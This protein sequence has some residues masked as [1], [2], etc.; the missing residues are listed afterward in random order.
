MPV[1][2]SPLD[3]P[4]RLLRR[5]LLLLLS[6]LS[7]TLLAAPRPANRISLE[8]LG[9][10]PL[11]PR[12]LLDGSSMLALH[13]VDDTHLLVT[14]DARHL[15][16]RIPNDPPTDQDHT[17]AFL[18]LELPT[19]RLLAR[20][21]LLVH[22][23]GQYLWNLGNGEFLLRQRD[24]FTTFVPLRN[25]ASGKAFVQ[26]PFLHTDRH[27]VAVLLSP[28]ADFLTIESTDP[29][30]LVD[31]DPTFASS[32]GGMSR[33]NDAPN[34][35]APTHVQLNFYRL[36]PPEPASGQIIPRNAGIALSRRP[37]ELPLSSE[38]L[39]NVLDQGRQR[40]AFDFKSHAGKRIE[41]AL[42]DSTCRPIPYFISPSEFLVFG[43][44]GGVT[45]Q[46][47]AAFNLRGD[48]T[49][50]QV[51][52]GSYVSPSFV[53]AP[54]A[55][56]FAL[57]RLI[58]NAAVAGIDTL[59]PSMV[60]GESVDVIQNDSGK[61]L[62]HIDCTPATRAGQ[63]FALSPDG[64][65]LAVIRD[66]GIEIYVLPALAPQDKTAIQLAVKSAPPP[67]EAAVDL[68]EI[69][70][71]TQGLPGRQNSQDTNDTIPFNPSPATSQSVT[72]QPTTAVQPPP[73]PS[74][75]ASPTASPTQ[76]SNPTAAPT[77]ADPPVRRKP[78]TLYN[79]PA[80]DPA[81][82]PQ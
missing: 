9:F 21:E 24:S 70:T 46:T 47:I 40:W 65:N 64:M 41:L 54:S 34:Q 68:S 81:Q 62:F 36:S 43:C 78:P 56:R 33:S 52:P 53:F 50:Q 61:T 30:P 58:I 69:S 27:V 57:G 76:A 38:G 73:E 1:P 11:P 23:H 77:Q 80:P 82:P 63:N 51:L 67:T 45:R 26:Y 14:F 2:L 7:A 39:I 44:H 4:R 79:P 32:M 71:P 25:L 16:P 19:G 22:D 48:A 37:I 8:D 3:H 20:S 49:W 59:D 12:Y 55:G 13:Y 28:Q 10:M 74:P 42:F 15:I 60:L 5:P 35:P 72:S 31:P 29:L 17:V 66:A 18:L 6:L 75:A